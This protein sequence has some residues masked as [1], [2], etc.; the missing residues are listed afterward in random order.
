[1][2][3]KTTM[4]LFSSAS[5]Q[6]QLGKDEWKGRLFLKVMVILLLGG[7]TSLV[8]Q[9]SSSSSSQEPSL[10]LLKKKAATNAA[11]MKEDSATS[12]STQQEQQQRSLVDPEKIP[13]FLRSY[14]QWHREQ[15]H[16]LHSGQLNW[17]T[18]ITRTSTRS[19]RTSC[20]GFLILRCAD[21]DRCGGLADRIK[22]FPF[23]ILIAAKTQ[24]ILY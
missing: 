20:R 14:F 10:V 23:I 7:A 24:R 12:N 6:Q 3:Q 17:T 19:T 2:R 11:M 1:M 18:M 16:L 5:Q 21:R 9:P 13:H 15:L 8:W 4:N 22:A